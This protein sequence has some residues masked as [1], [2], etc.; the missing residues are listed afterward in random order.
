M[1]IQRI[2]G[3]QY[4]CRTTRPHTK[5]ANAKA[6]QAYCSA[7]IL[8]VIDARQE[9]AASIT[10][11]EADGVGTQEMKGTLRAWHV[12]LPLLALPLAGC[13]PYPVYKRIQPEIVVRVVD[14]AGQPIP[15]ARLVLLTRAHPA[16]PIRIVTEA[17]TNAAGEARFES[18]REWQVEV[19]FIHGSLEYYWTLCVTHAGYANLYVHGPERFSGN[20]PTELVMQ[21][22]TASTCDRT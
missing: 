1:L 20:S 11:C 3:R 9:N 15:D 19:N 21:P 12:L 17:S 7:N 13:L 5:S 10:L 4:C 6:P 2:G 16:P 8:G 14:A 18:H 22:G